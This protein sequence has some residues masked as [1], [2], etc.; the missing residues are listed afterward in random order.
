M[1]MQELERAAELEQRLAAEYAAAQADAKKR[2]VIE[3]RAGARL[4]E[5]SRRSGEVESRRMMDE[6]ERRAAEKTDETLAQAREACEEMKRK[7]RERLDD[8]AQWIM[9]KVVNNEWQS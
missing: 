9:E 5:D 8:T 6:A 2:I 4:I 1:A 3:Q 7:A